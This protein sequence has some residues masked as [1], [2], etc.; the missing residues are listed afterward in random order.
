[1]ALR[2]RPGRSRDELHRVYREHVDAVFAFL[3]YSVDRVTA[4]DLT[5]STF[6]RVIRSWKRF[7]P[8]RGSERTW[9]LTIARNL[10]IDHYRSASHR[11]TV[12]T[13]DHPGLLDRLTDDSHPLQR[14]L[15]AQ[16]LARLLAPLNERERE[17]LALRYAADLS[18]AEVAE[19][20]NLTV[21]NVQQISSRSLRRLRASLEGEEPDRSGQGQ[22]LT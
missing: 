6:E 3:S 9:V 7:D 8:A 10:L 21:A 22:R 17:V 4:E 19:L 18:T 15:S 2:R 13:D 14:R 12:S 5:A 11:S 20:L 16:E 1:M